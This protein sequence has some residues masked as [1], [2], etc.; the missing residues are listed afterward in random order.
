MRES[1]ICPRCGET[2]NFF[3]HADDHTRVCPNCGN[4]FDVDEI[5]E[6]KE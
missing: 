5:L 6:V 4:L 2:V 1:G 3:I